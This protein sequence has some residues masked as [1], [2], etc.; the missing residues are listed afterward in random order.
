MLTKSNNTYVVM[1]NAIP[2][3]HEPNFTS[4]MITI[5]KSWCLCFPVFSAV[6]DSVIPRSNITPRLYMVYVCTCIIHHYINSNNNI[7]LLVLEKWAPWKQSWIWVRRWLSL[8][9]ID[10][11]LWPRLNCNIWCNVKIIPSS[12]KGWSMIIFVTF[13]IKIDGKDLLFILAYWIYTVTIGHEAPIYFSRKT[14]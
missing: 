12:I 11:L 10:R 1:I 5:I 6:G 4:W 3:F 2:N 14:E 9:T 8:F 7:N 13:W